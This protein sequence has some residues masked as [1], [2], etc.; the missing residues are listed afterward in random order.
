M[1]APCVR[2]EFLCV[3]HVVLTGPVSTMS[4]ISCGSYALS[5]PLLYG[6]L[7]PWGRDLIGT[8]C[9]GL[10]VPSSATLC[11]LFVSEALHLLPSAVGRSF[12]ADEAGCP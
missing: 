11:I 8:P 9:L 1:Q 10:S 3:G 4:P 12:S 7:R 5:V 2:L 6:S